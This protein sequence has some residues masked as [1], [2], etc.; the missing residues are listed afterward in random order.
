METENQLLNIIKQALVDL[1]EK[2]E[3]VLCSSDPSIPAEFLFVL[4]KQLIPN[5]ALSSSELSGLRSLVFHAI[6]DDRFFDW[7]MPTLTGFQAEEFQK[8]AEK[9][10][11]G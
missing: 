2:G 9:L 6:R 1:D 5:E 11:K 3:I 7:E 10:P 4:V 8:I